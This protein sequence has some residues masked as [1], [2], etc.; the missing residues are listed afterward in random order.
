MKNNLLLQ[1][2][3][4]DFMTKHCIRPQYAVTFTFKS[5]A[6]I[7][8]KDGAVKVDSIFTEMEKKCPEYKWRAEDVRG[9]TATLT[10]DIAN[11][12]VDYFYAKLTH[13]AYGKDSKKTSTKWEFARPYVLQFTFEPRPKSTCGECKKKDHGYK[14]CS[15]CDVTR[16]C[17]KECQRKHWKN[18][19]EQ[20]KKYQKA[21]EYDDEDDEEEDE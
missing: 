12:T 5:K 3:Y 11:T 8:Y 1:E 14:K 15:A 2:N 9:Y 19:K 17:S 18:H 20:C 21:G 4:I 13:K 10:E 16:Y 7:E 6:F